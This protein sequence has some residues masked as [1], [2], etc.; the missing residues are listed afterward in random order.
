[1]ADVTAIKLIPKV[2]GD[3]INSNGSADVLV[4][5]KLD[6]LSRSLSD[7]A[8][9][10]ATAQKQKWALVALDCQVDTSTPS[11][12]AMA[13]VMAVFSHLER[14]LISQRTREALAVKRAQG[15]K[16]GRPSTLPAT[17][18]RRILARTGLRACLVYR[19]TPVCCQVIRAKLNIS[20]ASWFSCFLDQRISSA[21]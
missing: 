18:V 7:F 14:R 13:H 17:T 19:R 21:R 8:G 15:V 4:A 11:G 5:A 20:S 10:M 3:G 12:E 9:L 1:M 16:L 6:R 2:V